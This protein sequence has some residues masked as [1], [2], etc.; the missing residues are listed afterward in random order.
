MAPGEQP[1]LLKQGHY[2][3]TTPTP[4]P[5]MMLV[6]L[7]CVLTIN[8]RLTKPH[9]AHSSSLRRVSRGHRTEH[10]LYICVRKRAIRKSRPNF[11]DGK[12]KKFGIRNTE[13]SVERARSQIRDLA[14]AGFPVSFEVSCNSLPKARKP[15]LAK[16]PRGGCLE[17]ESSIRWKPTGCAGK[18]VE[19]G[20]GAGRART[21]W[22]RILVFAFK[23]A[24][25]TRYIGEK[26]KLDQ[27]TNQPIECQLSVSTTSMSS[28]KFLRVAVNTPTCCR[29]PKNKK[30]KNRLKRPCWPPP[31]RGTG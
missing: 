5:H 6:V 15:T 10:L 1:G 26:K 21:L 4:T 24:F 27:S 31:A 29:Q 14:S 3:V 2:L 23:S 16:T 17:R 12:T 30:N 8:R 20:Q 13:V 9:L 25:E 19:V 11:T 28:E 22:P 7:L 18:K